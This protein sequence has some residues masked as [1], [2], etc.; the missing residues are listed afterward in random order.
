MDRKYSA[1]LE[2][3][4]SRIS[5]DTYG[6]HSDFTIYLFRT[7]YDKDEKEKYDFR[8]SIENYSNHDEKTI[9]RLQ[10]AILTLFTM[11]E[12]KSLEDNLDDMSGDNHLKIYHREIKFPIP[13]DF[14][15]HDKLPWS[16][17]SGQ[18][19]GGVYV[20][21]RFGVTGYYD[22]N[23]CRVLRDMFHNS[24]QCKVEVINQI[25]FETEFNAYVRND[26]SN[27]IAFY[28]RRHAQERYDENKSFYDRFEI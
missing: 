8:E 12:I 18:N 28:D 24:A 16:N 9:N 19:L 20:F 11:E 13:S 6:A 17:P 22:L 14:A 23:D 26:R 10:D 27:E 7:H 5:I 21:S 15:S 4:S 1:R 2:I 3:K 25:I